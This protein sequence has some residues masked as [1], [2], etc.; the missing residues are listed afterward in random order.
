MAGGIRARHPLPRAP[1]WR[2]PP[3]HIRSPPSSRTAPADLLRC[4]HSQTLPR[5]CEQRQ[6]RS[7]A[8]RRAQRCAAVAYVWR[9]AKAPPRGAYACEGAGRRRVPHG[10]A[11]TLRRSAAAGERSMHPVRRPTRGAQLTPRP[12]AD[13]AC[14]LAV[15]Q[16][17][18][19]Q[20][21]CLP[22]ASGGEETRVGNVGCGGALPERRVGRGGT[23]RAA[24]GARGA[25]VHG[26]GLRGRPQGAGRAVKGAEKQPTSSEAR[27]LTPLCACACAC[28]C[29]SLARGVPSTPFAG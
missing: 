18:P 22:C 16:Q 10:T 26:A 19:Q 2:C 14:V 1:R 17:Q 4:C 3:G 7:A 11:G 25:R 29:A 21:L 8:R 9:P 27:A 23:R 6:V 20:H 15:P 13:R 28:A 5:A 24:D 12:L